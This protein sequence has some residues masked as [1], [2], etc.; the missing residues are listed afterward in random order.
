[1]D[2]LALSGNF[3]D[4]ETTPDRVVERL[5][6]TLK[7]ADKFRNLDNRLFS[8]Q[9]VVMYQEIFNFN[10]R[11]FTMAPYVKHFFHDGP[12]K[13]S[14]DQINE[15]IS[16][17]VG[18]AVV[19]GQH[20]T[21][22]SL[23]LTLLSE[24]YEHRFKVISLSCGP[25]A[26]R[27]DLLQA[28]L[29][30]LKQPYHDL[31]EGELRLSLINFIKPTEN[32]PNGVL[33]LVDDA[34]SL[35]SDL[36][37]E[38]RL[39]TNFVRDGVPRV[40]LVLC[41]TGRLEEVLTEPKLEPFNQRISSRCFLGN[42]TREQ[43]HSYIHE[44]IARVGGDAEAMFEQDTTDAIHEATC[45]CPRFIN[46]LAEQCMIYAAT[47]G[48][49]V[50]ESN[51]VETAWAQVQGLPTAD[52]DASAPV[53]SNDEN[54]T[55]IEFGTLDD[56]TDAPTETKEPSTVADDI[57]EIADDA[58]ELP[59]DSLAVEI[60][61]QASGILAS[62]PEPVETEPSWSDVGTFDPFV[63]PEAATEVEEAGD[64]ADVD[65]GHQPLNSE[66][67]EE[68]EVPTEASSIPT[69]FLALA[70][71]QEETWAAAGVVNDAPSEE[72]T[73]EAE[74]LAEPEI[75]EQPDE[76]PSDSEAASSLFGS[77][78]PAVPV[79][80]AAAAAS[81][82]NPFSE[83]F[84]SEEPVSNEFNEQLAE[85]N[86]SSMSVT[87]EQLDSLSPPNGEPPSSDNIPVVSLVEEVQP[88][89]E[90]INEPTAE[91]AQLS[92]ESSEDEAVEE[93]QP[94]ADLG[95]IEA[96]TEQPTP[97]EY[98]AD[99]LASAFGSF[100]T[101]ETETADSEQAIEDPY[102]A[103]TSPETDPELGT[104]ID[105]T[106]FVDEQIDS[107]AEN[108]HQHDTRQPT[109]DIQQQ[110]DEILNSIRTPDVE[111]VELSDGTETYQPSTE[112]DAELFA[113]QDNSEVTEAQRILSEILEHKKLLSDQIATPA[114]AEADAPS[115]FPQSLHIQQS[116]STD[117]PIDD[118]AGSDSDSSTQPQN[119]ADPSSPNSP[120]NPDATPASIGRATRMNYEKLF[121]QLRDNGDQ[122]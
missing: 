38:L 110:A 13:Q 121:D 35:S 16:R 55:V 105:V 34:Q 49:M 44:H 70:Q 93:A 32:C 65:D 21:G 33:L 10:G 8:T 95:D 36:V 63:A 94:S 88:T 100:A 28:I 31:S 77:A 5:T 19:I 57:S 98:S 11:P 51:M 97:P 72:S 85:Q 82:A 20:G 90:P 45:G 84:E 46:Q 86:V 83:A 53:Q 43:T 78:L 62:D 79:I 96:E 114:A 73:F 9:D 24:Q 64:R 103:P 69:E 111:H 59:N 76:E 107:D 112:Q 48:S 60:A 116:F 30:E 109:A 47:H 81:I 120:F 7:S 119:L 15:S 26:E 12:V 22:K 6:T 80:A 52:A 122:S 3:Q 106:A 58:D 108:F 92:A 29:F 37:D 67:E 101:D 17:D 75:T 91:D 4:P 66:Q 104:A 40:R 18:P 89:L 68:G 14:L 71:D 56:E 39:V 2:S 42:L 115:D 25:M 41:G 27:R 87:G 61:G 1:M 118:H 74:S 99:E 117:D 54:W 113:A 102:L 23:L 50:V